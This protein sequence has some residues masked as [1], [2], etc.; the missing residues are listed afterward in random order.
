MLWSVYNSFCRTFLYDNTKK[1]VEHGFLFFLIAKK[2]KNQKELASQAL[3][4][5]F[6]IFYFSN[7]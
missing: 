6:F 2:N 7:L 1:N 3:Y 5:Y 4:F